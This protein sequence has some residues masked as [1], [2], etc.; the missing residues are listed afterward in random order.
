M[1]LQINCQKDN[2]SISVESCPG[3]QSQEPLGEKIREIYSCDDTAGASSRLY[4]ISISC[5][6]ISKQVEIWK[7]RGKNAFSYYND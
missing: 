2:L 4:V 7:I 6:L 3:E 5:L 1:I